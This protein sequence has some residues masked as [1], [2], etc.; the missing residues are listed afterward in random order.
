MPYPTTLTA[1]LTDAFTG[2]YA[3]LMD[4]SGALVPAPDNPPVATLVSY[5]LA[6][7]ASYARQAATSSP[8]IA[9]DTAQNRAEALATV[10]FEVPEVGTTQ[11]FDAVAL[12]GFSATATV[13]DTGGRLL[14]LKSYATPKTIT[15]GSAKTITFA[16][17]FGAATANVLD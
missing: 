12:L 2:C 16:I 1:I 7:S 4:S 11:T 13:G 9:W 15:P 14:A 3:I 5:E 10:S 8:A 6:A 17:N